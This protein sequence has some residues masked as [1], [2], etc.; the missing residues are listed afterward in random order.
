MVSER[1]QRDARQSLANIAPAGARLLSDAE[2]V[3]HDFFTTLPINGLGESEFAEFRRR[4]LDFKST[5]A[6]NRQGRI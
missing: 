6:R 3:M 4:L 1:N 2:S 5:Q